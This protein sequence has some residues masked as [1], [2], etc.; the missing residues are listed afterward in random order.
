MTPS[1]VGADEAATIHHDSET[2]PLLGA[3]SVS[4]QVETPTIQSAEGG[5]P[6]PE[7][8]PSQLAASQSVEFVLPPKKILLKPYIEYMNTKLQTKDMLYPNWFSLTPTFPK[9]RLQTAS[10]QYL[11]ADAVRSISDLSP[12]GFWDYLLDTIFALDVWDFERRQRLI[13]ITDDYIRP[14]W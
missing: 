5:S 6:T 13:K 14:I 1:D 4:T 12:K 7:P 2:D 11:N 9:P 8:Q 10:P 3:S